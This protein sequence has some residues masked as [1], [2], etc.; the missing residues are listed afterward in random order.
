MD[1]N[2]NQSS[3][4]IVMRKSLSFLIPYLFISAVII[5]LLVSYGNTELFLHINSYHSAFGDFLFFYLTN[6]GDGVV[7]ALL[8]LVLLWI[9]FREAL[10]F[11]LI[12]LAIT[13]I[14]NILKDHIFP[15]LD[16]PASYFSGLEVLHLVPGYDPPTL[17]TFPSGHTATAFS[18]GLY[19]S[20]LIKNR[21][22]KFL[23]FVLAVGVGYSRMYLAAHFP[24]DVLA[25][26]AI[27]V[28]TTL[29]CF[30]IGRLFKSEWIDKKI[31]YMPK[32][33]AREKIV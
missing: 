29:I 5:A 14:V 4:G 11:L 32:I 7:A 18:V 9:S 27:G 13:I 31:L 23:L 19:L 21:A 8:I 16:R 17:S 22:V 3:S 1:L 26:A 30:D 24:L 2:L 20:F 6:L 28:F 25:G 10:T 15:E 12:T 33:F